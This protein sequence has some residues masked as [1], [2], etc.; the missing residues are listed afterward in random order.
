MS[1]PSANTVILPMNLKPLRLDA[2]THGVLLFHGLSSGPMEL[3]FVARGLQRAGYSV[4]AP[5]IAGYTHGL[6][7]EP[8]QPAGAEQWVLAALREFDALAERCER[9]SIGGL[10]IGAVLSLRVAALRAG[11]VSS[12]LAMSTALHFDG[13]ANPW[14]TPF[15]NLGRYLPFARRI[16]IREGEPYGLKDERMRA[17]VKR[18]MQT[19]GD[20][21]AGAAMLMVGDLLKARDLIALA[22]SSLTQVTAP[23]LL[24][25]A[26]EDECAT[27][28]S[29]YEVANCIGASRIQILILVNSYHM[30]SLDQEKNTVISAMQVFLADDAIKADLK[31]AQVQAMRPTELTLKVKALS[32]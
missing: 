29:S 32:S 5:V 2:G 25:H 28:R 4:L 11:R 19:N 21:N 31:P 7:P 3:Q 27:P 1:D 12:V 10:C 30:V 18:Q 16:A 23:S 14:Y 26:R 13:W 24:I 17:W 20:S 8:G 22:K 6:R 9:V 15:L